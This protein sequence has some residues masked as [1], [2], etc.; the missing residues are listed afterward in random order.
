[1]APTHPLLPEAGARFKWRKALVRFVASAGIFALVFW[2]ADL[3][4]ARIREGFAKVDSVHWAGALAAFLLLHGVSAMKW[5]LFLSLAGA[6]IPIGHALRYYAA[7]LFSNLCLPSLVGGDAVRAGLAMQEGK[8]KAAVLLGG[9]LDR[10]FDLAALGALVAVGSLLAPDAL[11]RMEAAHVEPWTILG[12]FFGG[13]LFASIACALVFVLRPPE[14]WPVFSEKGKSVERALATVR[15]RPGRAV[16]GLSLCVLIQAGFVA[17]N[18]YL[19]GVMGV[20]LDL[21]LWYLV[22]PLAKIAAMMPVS[23][24]GIGVREAAISFLTAPFGE[25]V[26]NLAVAQSLVWQTVLV[27]GGVLAGLV[28]LLS[29]IARPRA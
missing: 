13:L 14:T 22:Y 7:G 29:G 17:V 15:K 1:M 28:W 26:Q 21:A 5:R 4:W 6:E 10:F 19:G 23:L 20:G 25:A 8:S 9:A 27:A 18:A 2:L 16:L 12:V 3:D 11:L 24:G